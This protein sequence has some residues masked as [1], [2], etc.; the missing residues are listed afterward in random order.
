MSWS[1]LERLVSDAEASAELRNTLRRCRCRRRQLLLH[2][3]RHLGYRVTRTD[4]QNAWGEHQQGQEVAVQ[5]AG[6][7]IAAGI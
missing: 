7:A 2:S 5:D 4:L 1:E 3:A 6:S